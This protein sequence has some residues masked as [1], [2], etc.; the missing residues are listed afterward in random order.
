MVDFFFSFQYFKYI[1]TLPSGLQ[2]F[3]W[4]AE[5]ST[6]TCMGF[7]LYV[8]CFFSLDAFNIVFYTLCF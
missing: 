3:C 5:R 7:P 8:T 1:L 6:V 2:S 4:L